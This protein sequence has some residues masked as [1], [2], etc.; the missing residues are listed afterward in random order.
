[1]ALENK[2]IAKALFRGA[3]E[4]GKL[5][6]TVECDLTP[7]NVYVDPDHWEKIMFNLIGKLRSSALRAKAD[8]QEMRSSIL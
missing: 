1:M 4:R 3:I 2:L 8:R 5:R 7:R 6:Y